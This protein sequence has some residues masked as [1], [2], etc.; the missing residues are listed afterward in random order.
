VASAS[1]GRGSLSFLTGDSV[2]GFPVQRM[3]I[4]DGGNVGIG[5]LNARTTLDIY[6][7]A[8]P[9]SSGQSVLMLGGKSSSSVFGS[10]P[11]LNFVTGDGPTEN[12]HWFSMA[13]I[14][15]NYYATG[16][17]RLDF[18]TGWA[19]TQVP[20]MTLNHDGYLGIG[21]TSPSEMLSVVGNIHAT[22]GLVTSQVSTNSSYAFNMKN[23]SG[24][25]RG[26][27]YIDS[28]GSEL[29][30][31]DNSGVNQ[32]RIRHNGESFFNGGKVGVNTSGVATF[33][34]F[35]VGGYVNTDAGYRIDDQTALA[36]SGTTLTVGSHSSLT[37]T[38]IYANGSEKLSA[39]GNK[40][41]A[42]V[43]L[44]VPTYTVATLPAAATASAGAL[45]YVTDDATVG[46]T[47]V[48]SDGTNWKITGTAT[49]VS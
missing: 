47:H 28:G 17:T 21:T 23:A 8:N 30:L 5:L 36:K 10:G 45:A 48:T 43:P 24:V 3:V 9:S 13:K 33:S 37:A 7:T 22:G 1:N 25:N 42:L 39:Y 32:V 44:V 27:L 14:H 31:Y 2:T 40:I 46:Q 16:K 4:S 20:K 19:S 15:A 26:G 11:I 41:T 29:L 35:E 49:L 38:R 34:Q 18:W 6:S 12:T